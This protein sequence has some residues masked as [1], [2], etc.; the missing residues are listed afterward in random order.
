MAGT[1]PD[2]AVTR[3]IPFADTLVRWIREKKL[4]APAS[5][6]L[7]MHRPLMPLAYPAAVMFGTFIAPFVG[8]DYYEKIEALRTPAVLDDLLDRLAGRSSQPPRADVRA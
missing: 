8:P 7:E 6:F 3:D 1:V 5:F 2:I 4:E